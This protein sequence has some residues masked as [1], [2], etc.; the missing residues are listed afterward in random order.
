MECLYTFYT[1][2]ITHIL[3]LIG[4][5]VGE[6]GGDIFR[7]NAG[8]ARDDDPTRVYTQP[9]RLKSRVLG[10]DDP[11]SEEGATRVLRGEGH[12]CPELGGATLDQRGEGQ[13]CSERG[14]ATSV[15]RFA[16]SPLFRERSG[17]PFFK[18]GRGHP[19]SE[20]GG[21]ARVQRGE[22]AGESNLCSE[23]G[24]TSGR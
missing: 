19:C 18:E 10:R 7:P 15:Q 2:S 1:F 6:R 4:D 12:L 24:G 11:G 8:S 5:E 22:V 16:P 21:A 3:N 9:G 13:P 14:K 20:R 23:R 17:H